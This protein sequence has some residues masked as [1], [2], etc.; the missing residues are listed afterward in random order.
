MRRRDL[1]RLTATGA[2]LGSGTAVATA[3]DDP[4]TGPDDDRYEG[5]RRVEYRPDG[6]EVAFVETFESDALRERFGRSVVTLDEGSVQ[7]R[8]LP[9]RYRRAREPF[10]VERRD[11][12]VLAS[13]DEF[14]ARE[15]RTKQTVARTAD[16]TPANLDVLPLYSYKSADAD[17][18]ERTG[19]INVCWDDSVDAD[20][21]DVEWAM[22]WETDYWDGEC[23]CA[24]LPSK[25]RY[26][27]VD[28]QANPPQDTGVAKSAGFTNQWHARLWDLPD[29]RVVAQSHY[30]TVDHCQL[31]TDCDFRFDSSRERVADTWTTDIGGYETSYDWLGNG[32]GYTDDGSADGWLAT[33]ERA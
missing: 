17:I 30:D 20:A 1:L 4:A 2:V 32:S 9:R 12:A 11:A 13:L 5:V 25:D 7:R 22:T 27:V 8:A 19:P 28:G 14:A 18:A 23:W 10:T 3:R 26:V 15:R 6:N 16:A 21:S 24:D 29:G 33:I 31:I